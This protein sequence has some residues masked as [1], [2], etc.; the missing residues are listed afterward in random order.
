MG[1][2][3]SVIRRRWLLRLNLTNNRQS[4]P[5]CGL[6]YVSLLPLAYAGIMANQGG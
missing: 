3:H 1:R 6:K 4:S 2:L 5:A